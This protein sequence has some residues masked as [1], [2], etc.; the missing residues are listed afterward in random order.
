MNSHFATRAQQAEQKSRTLVFA[1]FNVFLSVQHIMMGVATLVKLAHQGV[2]Y[3]PLYSVHTAIF[4]YLF[5]S[6]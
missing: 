2:S 4:I 3:F 6:I 5:S 1:V